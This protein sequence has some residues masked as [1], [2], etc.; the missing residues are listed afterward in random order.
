MFKKDEKIPLLKQNEAE[1]K[2][3]EKRAHELEQLMA[4][5]KKILDGLKKDYKIIA[6]F[7]QH[8]VNQF[9]ID[10]ISKTNAQDI[11]KMFSEKFNE[12]AGKYLPKNE[13]GEIKQKLSPIF[14]RMSNSLKEK[15]HAV[16]FEDE[17]R[18]HAKKVNEIKIDYQ[19]QVKPLLKIIKAKIVGKKA[20][21][22]N[23]EK[24]KEDLQPR[25]SYSSSQKK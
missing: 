11:L 14:L 17:A 4:A 23:L 20:I 13:L 10:K 22:D 6:D 18:Q 15:S 9:D 12:M 19:L 21:I 25:K 24:K 16:Y 8:A 2:N 1:Q 7:Y 5:E 3:L